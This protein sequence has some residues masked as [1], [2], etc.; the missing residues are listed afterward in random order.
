M[1][2]GTTPLRPGNG[3]P[4]SNDLYTDKMIE[5]LNR[6]HDDGKPF[7][8]YLAF[9]VAH[10]PFMSPPETI[11]K[12]NTIYSAGWDQISEQRFEKQKELGIWPANMTLSPG[13]PPNEP[14]SS[15]DQD[16][17]DY[18]KSLYLYPLL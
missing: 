9:Q 2:P 17:K 16:E 15:L 7:F 5:Y 10:S 12:Y 6:T 3:I 13:Q 14:W 11:E 1:H 18:A 4:F 8:G